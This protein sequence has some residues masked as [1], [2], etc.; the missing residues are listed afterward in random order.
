MVT[1]GLLAIVLVTG[2]LA[3]GALL[4]GGS[5]VSSDD[6]GKPVAVAATVAAKAADDAT[7]ASM[8]VIVIEQGDGVSIQATVGGLSNGSGY[9]L[10]AVTTDGHTRPIANWTSDGK[11]QELN[12]KLPVPISSLVLFTVNLANQGPVVSAY[13]GP[14]TGGN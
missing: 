14:N 1:A 5:D 2:G 12:G 9:R 3:L 13:L 11:V 4:N 7:G 6:A 10:Q 8:S